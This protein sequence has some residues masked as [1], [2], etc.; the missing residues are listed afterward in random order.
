LNVTHFT[1]S[2]NWTHLVG[3]FGVERRLAVGGLMANAAVLWGG[4]RFVPRGAWRCD[5]ANSLL[6][7]SNQQLRDGNRSLWVAWP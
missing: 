3:F 6:L 5:R 1:A 7:T 4:T 2:R